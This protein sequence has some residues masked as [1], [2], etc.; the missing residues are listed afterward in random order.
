MPGVAHD[1]RAPRAPISCLKLQ[2]PE[3][4]PI[5]KNDVLDVLTKHG[6][7]WVVPGQAGQPLADGLLG[8]PHVASEGV[9]PSRV[10]GHSYQRLPWSS[11]RYGRTK[12]LER[13]TRIT[14]HATPSAAVSINM[15]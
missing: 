15:C 2:K 7:W 12:C 9:G 10:T 6:L 1:V 8:L 11:G 3:P 5:H 14:V 13:R 4:V